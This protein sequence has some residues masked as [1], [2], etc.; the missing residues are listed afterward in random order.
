[1][2]VFDV[3]AMLIPWSVINSCVERQ[4]YTYTWYELSTK[5]V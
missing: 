1:M 5:C 4:L 3:V 2:P